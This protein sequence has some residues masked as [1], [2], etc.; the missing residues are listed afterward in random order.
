LQSL[1]P[2]K[3]TLRR[4][5]RKATLRASAEQPPPPPEYRGELSVPGTSATS[6]QR[7]AP[8]LDVEARYAALE[9]QVAKIAPLTA[10]LAELKAKAERSGINGVQAL[11]IAIGTACALISAYQW[12]PLVREKK[13]R[14]CVATFPLSPACSLHPHVR[15]AAVQ[16]MANSDKVAT[17]LGGVGAVVGLAWVYCKGKLDKLDTVDAKLDTV[18]AKLDTVEAK[19]DTVEAKLDT[20]EGQLGDVKVQLNKLLNRSWWGFPAS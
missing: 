16:I 8:P 9:A 4:A 10:Q 5:L 2:R 15:S 20:V 12:W 7:A 14:T 6:A 17:A 11:L 3:G 1:A 13:K 18:E 19:L